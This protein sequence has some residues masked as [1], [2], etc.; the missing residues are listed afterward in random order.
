MELRIIDRLCIPALL[1]KEGNFR[2]YNLKKSILAKVE[3]TER[4]RTE[5]NLR[6]DP[7]TNRIEWDVEKDTPTA[8]PFTAEEMEFLKDSCERLAE[9]PHPDYLWG[10][11]E[12]IYNAVQSERQAEKQE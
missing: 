12:A 8:I 11:I 3:I 2:Q 1:P 10:V 9:E 5:V 7:E 4:E 6:Q